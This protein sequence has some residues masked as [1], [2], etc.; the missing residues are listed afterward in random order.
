MNQYS[1]NRLF[2]FDS[3]TLMNTCLH[4]FRLRALG[5][6]IALLSFAAS[7][8][9]E[10]TVEIRGSSFQPSN[11]TI[12]VGVTVT[13]IQRDAGIQH[14]SA[15]DTGVWRGPLLSLNQTFS[16]TFDTAGSFPYH[17]DPHPFMRGTVTVQAAA[18]QLPTVSITNPA[19][20]A[21]FEEGATVTLEATASDP[22]GNVAQVGFFRG[23]TSLGIATSAPY[24]VTTTLPVGTHNLTAQAT[25][26][27]GGIASSAVVTVTVTAPASQPSLSAPR[28]LPDGTF[29]FTV[30]GTVDRTYLVQASSDGETW[31]TIQ[32]VPASTGEFNVM[33]GQASTAPL[34]FYRVMQQ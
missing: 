19:N 4:P 25:D 5:L 16:H 23:R 6:L 2:K 29:Q 11:V 18:N 26:D 33:D 31:E 3:H 30:H 34:R 12:N 27:Q 8:A 14:N 22:D 32:T 15:S 10:I 7:E 17:C 20:G 9:A 1:L 21:T 13:W 28:K 24:Q